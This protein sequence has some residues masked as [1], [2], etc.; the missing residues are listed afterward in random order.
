[1]SDEFVETN[2]ELGFLFE[3]N[4]S[5]GDEDSD[6]S[7][8]VYVYPDTAT[9]PSSLIDQARYIVSNITLMDT[10][11]RTIGQDGGENERLAYIRLINDE[12]RF[13]YWATRFNTEWEVVFIING[14]NDWTCLGIPD[15]QNAGA[16]IR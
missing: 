4:M 8:E 1:M 6:L 10:H 2:E 12:A 14:A 9:V 5:V 13:C 7:F 16:Y 15:G 3:A 11:A